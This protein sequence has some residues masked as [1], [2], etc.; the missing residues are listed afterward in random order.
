MAQQESIYTQYMFNRLIINPAYAGVKNCMD[1]TMVYRHQ[2][3][4]FPNAPKQIALSGHT[5]IDRWNSGIGIFATGDF[6]GAFR[7]T[8]VGF[9][10]AYHIKINEQYHLSLGL[11]GAVLQF[12]I[13]EDLISVANN[14]DVT[15]AAQTGQTVFRP[16]AGAGCFLVSERFYVGAS[17]LHIVPVEFP[18][19]EQATASRLI[20]H[21]FFTAGGDL[22]IANGWKI[23][24]STFIRYASRTPFQADVS[25]LLTHKKS[26]WFGGGYR[27]NDALL[28]YFGIFIRENLRLGYSFDFTTSGL[29]IGNTFGTHE[30]MLKYTICKK[31]ANPAIKRKVVTPEYF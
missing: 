18:V 25:A 24:P 12:S 6:I 8:S 16:D 28:F 13:D 17:A 27:W 30:L 15:F 20:P 1:L 14:S 7:N 4:S 9:D 26:L 5:A 19:Y 23:S 22:K 10:Y 31:R 2:W 3:L 29:N 21:Y 11:Q